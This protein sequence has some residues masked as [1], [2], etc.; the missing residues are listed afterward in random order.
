MSVRSVIAALVALAMLSACSKDETPKGAAPAD[1]PGLAAAAVGCSRAAVTPATGP[2][3]LTDATARLGALD[4]LKG[5]YGHAAAMGDVNGDGWL[6]LFAGNFADKA[7]EQYKVRGASG[8]SPDK[9]L[10]GGPDGFAVDEQFP[11]EFGRTSGAAL[12]DLDGDGDLDLVVTRNTKVA[13]APSGSSDRPNKEKKKKDSAETAGA[14]PRPL[15]DTALLRNDGAGKFTDVDNP[16]TNKTARAVA[17]LD[18]DAD[19]KLDLFV[20]EDRFGGGKSVLLRNEGG[21]KFADTTAAAGLPTDLAGLAAAAADLNGDRRPDLFVGGANKLFVNTGGKF[22]AVDTGDTFTWETF[23]AE[24]DVA[25]VAV[26]DLNRD[27]MPDLVLGQHY[28]STQG[29]KQQVPIRLYLNR[30]AKDG[31]PQFDDV[32]EK[33]KVPAFPTKAPHVE[34]LDI[35]NDGWLDILATAS[36][37][38]GSRP[39]ILRQDR[40]DGGVPVF[41]APSGMGDDRYWVT[42]ATG[43]VDCDGRVDVFV[44]AI[45]PDQPSLMLKN[46]TPSGHWLAI[47]VGSKT[48]PAVGTLVEVFKAGGLGRPQDLLLHDEITTDV[49]YA[50]GAPP[51][52]HA[53]LGDVSKVDVRITQPGADGPVTLRDVAADQMLQYPAPSSTSGSSP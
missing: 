10:L 22:E 33:A 8:P 4:P 40:R 34:L 26:G 48:H 31:K 3:K 24:D 19:G 25:G 50:G 38:D 27:G 7:D 1:R 37:A 39:A 35:D 51:V 16:V 41:A 9:L 14:A 36:V 5:M 11:K 6:D 21:L 43:D 29:D 13:G 30:G 32:T 12:A 49:G 28:N 20:V 46:E 17:V 15:V 52:V 44:V 53:G 45:A 2:V 18:Y 23:G 47:T 42:G